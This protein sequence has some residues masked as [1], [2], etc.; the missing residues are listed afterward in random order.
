MRLLNDDN[1][2]PLAREMIGDRC[3]DNPGAH[4]DHA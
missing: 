3:A 4:D 2:L 1:V